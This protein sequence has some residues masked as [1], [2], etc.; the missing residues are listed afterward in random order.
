MGGR[1]RSWVADVRAF[2]ERFRYPVSLGPGFPPA[3]VEE[4]QVTKVFEELRELVDALERRDLEGVAREIIDSIYALIGIGLALG[5][6]LEAAW[7][8]VHEAN[9][10]KVLVDGAV[11][12]PNGWQPPDMS[13]AVRTEAVRSV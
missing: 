1:G 4:P 6:D 11:M 10:R 12:K 8:E 9:M 13:R 5:L 2:R 7:E 3:E